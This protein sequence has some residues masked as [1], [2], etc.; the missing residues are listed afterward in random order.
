[1]LSPDFL[2]L[3]RWQKLAN[4][5]HSPGRHDNGYFCLYDDLPAFRTWLEQEHQILFF[6]AGQWE[7]LQQALNELEQFQGSV[8]MIAGL[9]KHPNPQDFLA[10]LAQIKN[11]YCP[12]RHFHWLVSITPAIAPEFRDLKSFM[13]GKAAHVDLRLT[14][15]DIEPPLEHFWRV[16][17]QDTIQHPPEEQTVLTQEL[18]AFFHTLETSQLDLASATENTLVGKLLLLQG[19]LLESQGEEGRRMARERYQESFDIWQSLGEEEPVI[20][21]ALRLAYLWLLEADGEPNR[22][23]ETW[24]QTQALVETAIAGLRKRQWRFFHYDTLEFLG[25]ILRRLENWEYLKQS[26]E[27][28]L[29]FFYQLSPFW[30]TETTAKPTADQPW[31]EAQLQYITALAYALLAEALMEQWKFDEAEAALKQAFEVMAKGSNQLT[32]LTPRLHYLSGRIYLANDQPRTALKRFQE[33]S[34]Q[35]TFDDDPPLFMAVLVELRAC[36][37]QLEDWQQVL[38]IEQCY[39][40]WEYQTGQRAFV[41]SAPLPC[42]LQQCRYRHPLAPEKILGGD[43][44]ASTKNL[45]TSLVS[46]SWT[47]LSSA[48]NHDLNPIVLLVGDGGSGKTSWIQ[49]EALSSL[50]HSQTLCIPF[51]SGCTEALLQELQLRFSPLNTKFSVYSDAESVEQIFVSQ[52]DFSDELWLILDGQDGQL[53]WQQ[54]LSKTTAALVVSLWRWLLAQI[55]LGSLKLL[56]AL[57]TSAIAPFQQLLTQALPPSKTRPPLVVYPL[58]RLTVSLA[59]AGLKTAMTGVH[60]PWETP[61]LSR[62][63]DDLV[64]QADHQDHHW[65]NPLDL[66]L[67]GSE[68]ETGGITHAADYQRQPLH[69]W[70]WQGIQRRLAL[71]PPILIK[72]A[73]AI[74]QALIHPQEANVQLPSLLHSPKTAAQIAVHIQKNLD[75]THRPGTK[76]LIQLLTLLRDCRLLTVSDMAGVIYYRLASDHFAQ[77]FFLARPQEAAL[78]DSSSRPVV[79][80]PS[81]GNPLV[82]NSRPQPPALGAEWVTHASPQE[83]ES[84]Q[85]LQVDKHKYQA[86]LVGVSLERHANVIL[87]QFESHPLDALAAAVQMGQVLQ[88]WV[89]PDTPFADYPSLAPVLTLNNILGQILERNRLQHS[90]SITC[91][92]TSAAVDNLPPL[93]L[94]ATTKGKAYIWSISGKLLATLDG[95]QAPVTAVA[96]SAN[97]QYIATASADNTVKLWN[98]QGEALVTLR[99]HGNWVRS[100]H[101]SPTHEHL[102]TSS[103]DCTIRLWDFTGQQLSQCDGHGNWVRNAAFDATGQQLISASRDGTARL[104]DLEGREKAVLQGHSHWV[105]NAQF[106]P[107]GQFIV[108]ASADNTARIWNQEGNCLR[109]LDGHHDWVRNAL[110]HPDGQRV[111]TA[112]SDGTARVWNVDGHCL[113]ILAGPPSVQDAGFSPNGERVVTCS[114]DGIVRLWNCDGNLMAILRGH[115]KSVF[116]AHFSQD[117]HCLLTVSADHTARLWNLGPKMGIV[118]TGHRHWVRQAH[119]SSRGDYLLTVSRD[120]TARIWNLAGEPLCVLEGHRG[121]VR[122]GIFSPDGELVATA[123]ADKT[124]QLWNRFGKKLATLQGHQ[125]AVLTIRFSPD[126]ERILTTSKDSTA[127]IWDRTGQTLAILQK[128][129]KIVFTAEF[130]RDGQSIVTASDDH[131]ARIWDTV[132]QEKGVCRGHTGPVYSAQF[133]PDGQSILTASADYTARVWNCAGEPITTLS[134]HQNIIYQAQ[135]NPDSD[136]IVTAAADQTARIWDRGGRC[137]AVLYGHQALVSSAQWSADGQL[138]VT[139]SNDGTARVWDRLGRELAT[140]DQ[141]QGSVRSAEF[142]P[143]NRWIIT[144]STDG[145]ARL[146]PLFSLGGLIEQG[147]HWLEPYLSRNSLV[148]KQAPALLGLHRDLELPPRKNHIGQSQ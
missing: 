36:Y 98:R 81:Q 60:S 49:G 44:V 27:N 43:V 107:D 125:D 34:Q 142:S 76:S 122:E 66:Q 17:W 65:I 4:L 19:W 8:L 30:E 101:F 92:Q 111:V 33:I 14:F 37:Q 2:K 15:T 61:L 131:T 46:L 96:W 11:N 47:E 41:D 118:L 71:L 26:A 58:P 24:Q 95:H 45:N 35:L 110:W 132:G 18:A 20:W 75:I 16:L 117:S 113:T 87:K 114:S 7:I 13:D 48:W 10:N 137:L 126:G 148:T 84:S 59:E 108:T 52:Q 138:L 136:L 134:G 106:S 12:N 56:V 141:H 67:L 70:I 73:I 77:A 29:I 62:V 146:W 54:P 120:K 6:D 100:V 38:H 31:S 79:A 119:F 133:S 90:T 102:V 127:R 74:G 63:L 22:G 64:Q 42:W 51:D 68:L 80:Q 91:L 53:P 139:A 93:I 128:H 140:L 99:G 50:P 78:R 39:Q 130:S 86:V 144:A 1:M 116:Q 57:P 72:Q 21:L 23:H 109:I 83:P 103:R 82:D 69:Q 85:R 112:S 129:S 94:T 147:S 121:L 5:L 115:Q 89:T 104:W 124:G 135:F 40:Q 25:Q 105:R 123:S 143:D 145:T 55:R 3:Q 97:A 88:Q 32:P 9:E 28:S